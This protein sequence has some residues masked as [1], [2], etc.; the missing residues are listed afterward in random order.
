VCLSV[1][2][3]FCSEISTARFLKINF[4]ALTCKTHF[5]VSRCSLAP[6]APL[7]LNLY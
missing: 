1:D 2:A 4:S 6:K 5:V 7:L 3:T